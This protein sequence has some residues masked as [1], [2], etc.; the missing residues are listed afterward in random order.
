M[1]WLLSRRTSI[2]TRHRQTNVYQGNVRRKGGEASVK[3]GGT[4]RTAPRRLWSFT[5]EPDD[6]DERVHLGAESCMRRAA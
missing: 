5:G 4:T 1:A 2:L 6:Q 3:E